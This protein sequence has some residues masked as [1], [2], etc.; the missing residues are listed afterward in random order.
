[1]Q[2]PTETI[3]AEI[4]AVARI[5]ATACAIETERHGIPMNPHDTA[6]QARAADMILNGAGELMR[7][8]TERTFSARE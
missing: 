5:V 7:Q 3:L 4:P 1:M 2:P 8:R 6:V